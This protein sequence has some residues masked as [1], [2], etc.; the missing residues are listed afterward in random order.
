[1]LDFCFRLIFGILCFFILVLL[2]LFLLYTI[3]FV[4]KDTIDLFCNK[5]DLLC[6]FKVV[7]ISKYGEY[8]DIVFAESAEDALCYFKRKHYIPLDSKIIVSKVGKN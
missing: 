1:M 8:F 6:E 7:R 2:L 5:K 4:I 3:I